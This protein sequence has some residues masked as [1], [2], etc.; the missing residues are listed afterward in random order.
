MQ[1]GHDGADRDVE[2]L[3]GVGV[4]KSPM[5]TSTTT[6]RKSCGTSASALDDVVLREPLE[7][8]LLLLG[9]LSP[10]DSSSRL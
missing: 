7:H 6:S 2:D 8:P 4:A 10:P 5:S 1:T 3:R 9:L